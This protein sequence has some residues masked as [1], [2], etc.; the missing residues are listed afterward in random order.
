MI[1]LSKIKELHNFEPGYAFWQLRQEL[2]QR[3]DARILKDSR[4]YDAVSALTS[5]AYPTEE[6]VHEKRWHCFYLHLKRNSY[7]IL[8]PLTIILYDMRFFLSFLH[9]QVEVCRG[10]EKND[11]YMGL[12][13]QCQKFSRLVRK[14]PEIVVKAV[15]NDIKTGRILGKYVMEDLL[16]SEKK[17]KILK[18]YGEHLKKDKRTDSVSVNDYLK[19]AALCYRACF[20]RKT[21]GMTAMQMYK[22]WADGRDCGLLEIKDKKSK[23]AFDYWLNHKSHCGG[24]PFEIVFSW[25]GHGLHL[26]PP[27]PEKSYFTLSVTDYMY[28]PL[29]LQMVEALIRNGI[30]FKAHEIEM[31]LDYLSGEIYF[32]VNDYDKHY[33]FYAEGNRKLL[34]HIEWDAPQILRWK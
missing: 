33:I 22:K 12:I 27:Y 26:R 34:R 1:K 30:A 9:S 19:T 21:S 4:L 18:L 8:I 28:A 3:H 16:P 31:V 17:E 20:G 6:T 32:T 14:N 2:P 15:P 24:H 23:E 7:F 10:A 5:K 11:F 13:G 29:F 25:H